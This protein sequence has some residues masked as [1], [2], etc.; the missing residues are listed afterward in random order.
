MFRNYFRTAFRNLAR[1]KVYSFI[2]IA[3][4]SFGLA[5]A[6]L[7]MLYIQDEV[8]YDRF[9]RNVS[10]IYRIDKQQKKNDGSLH[11]GSWTGYFPGPRFAARIPEIQSYVRFQPGFADVKTG[12]DIQSQSISITDRNFFSVFNFPLLSGNAAT[13]LAQPNSVVITEDMAKKYFGNLNAVGKTIS[14]NNQ[15]TFEPYI[16]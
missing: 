4:L 8:S 1:N 10:Q 5:C 12:S 6:M 3:G 2:N 15:G 14:I 13:V 7:I 11:S 9:H 16:V